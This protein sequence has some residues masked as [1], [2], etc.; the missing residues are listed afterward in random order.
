MITVADIMSTSLHTLSPQD[1]LASAAQLM[2]D[3][4]IRHIPILDEADQLVGLIS[5]RDLLAAKQSSVIKDTG[6]NTPWTKVTIAQIMTKNLTTVDPKASVKSAA[7]YIQQH[8]FGCLPVVKKEK[9]LGIITDTDFVA[10][11]INLL[12]IEELHASDEV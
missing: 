8:K 9:L 5:E 12:E 7:I 1:T 10:V 11:A 4:R 2:A 6:E 3:K